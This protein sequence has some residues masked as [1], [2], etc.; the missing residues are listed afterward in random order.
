MGFTTISPLY[1]LRWHTSATGTHVYFRPLFRIFPSIAINFS[2]T[3]SALKPRPIKKS[4]LT[5]K[6]SFSPKGI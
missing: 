2:M 4:V 6:R 1:F 5:T 3:S